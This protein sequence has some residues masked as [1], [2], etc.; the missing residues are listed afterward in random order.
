M[1][2]IDALQ[3]HVTKVYRR[4]AHRRQFAT[5]KSAILSGS[6]IRDL[7][8]DETFPALRNVTFSVK[9]GARAVRHHRT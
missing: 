4:Y 1:N 6:L 5:L 9:P 3:P 2:A 8:P 7:Q